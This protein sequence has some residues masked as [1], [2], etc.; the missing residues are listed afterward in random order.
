MRQG[1]EGEVKLAEVMDYRY[2][3]S[4][5]NN[6][7]YVYFS[8]KGQNAYGAWLKKQYKCTTEW[9]ASKQDWRFVDMKFL[10]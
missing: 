1:M 3:Y 9:D 5:D 7:F 2:E 4:L 6:Q 8:L 10:D